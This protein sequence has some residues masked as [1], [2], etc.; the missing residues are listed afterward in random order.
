M[1]LGSVVGSRALAQNPLRPASQLSASESAPPTTAADSPLDGQPYY[2]PG[3]T[4]V[5]DPGLGPACGPDGCPPF[6]P[7]VGWGPGC[8]SGLF[9]RMEYLGWSAAGMNLPPLVTTSPNGTRRDDAGVLGENTTILFGGDSIGDDMRSGGRI[10]FGR[11]FDPCQ[12][13]GVEADYFAIDDLA[14]SF[15]ASSTGSPI[16]ARPFYDVTQGVQ[17]SSLVAFPNVIQGTIAATH[18]TSFQGAGVRML[19]NLA[20]GEGCGTSCLTHCPV[21][22]GYR[23]D[24]ILGYRFVRLDDTLSMTEASTSLETANPG[25]FFIQDQFQTENQFHGVDFGSVLQFTKGCWSLDLLSKLALGSTRSLVTIAGSTVITQGDA[26]ESFTGG[27]LAQRTNSGSRTFDEFAIVPEIGATIGY[28]INP[29]W[30]MTVGY[31]FLYW[32][33]VARAGDQISNELNPDLLPPESAPVTTNLRPEFRLA[34]TDFWVQ[35]ISLGLEAK[36]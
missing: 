21:S 19:Y 26:G 33:R 10:T 9:V 6:G 8:F 23:F 32:S 13:L 27:F 4:I 22:T 24:T 35:G 5:G 15:T 30:R 25:A 28:Q 7:L 31:T 34:Y 36:W 16:L 17:S 14:T 11:W 29:C 3:Q 2:E 18:E 1:I 20:C 12:R